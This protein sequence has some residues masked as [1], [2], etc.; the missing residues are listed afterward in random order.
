M[1][2]HYLE[3]KAEHPDT[4]LLYRMGDF[5]EAFFE[6]AEL[7]APILE[8][9]LTAR[10]KGKPSET[11]MCGVP[12]HALEVY[13][14][15]L[16]R[17]GVRVAICDQVEDPAEAKGLVKREVT[18]VVTPG[19]VSD[20]DL[21]ESK[22]ENCLAAL[23]WEGERGAGAFLDVSTGSFGVARWDDVAECLEELAVQRPRE[24]LVPEE[25]LPEEIEV[26][27]GGQEVCVTRSGPDS[28]IDP[29]DAAKR[30][31]VNWGWTTFAVSSSSLASRR[32]GRRLWRCATS[33]RP[34]RAI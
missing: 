17:A 27:L 7:A 11:P 32:S 28:S 34:R 31:S 8:V 9:A 25:G 15:K 10:Q 30:S 21:L 20:P 29:R 2:R 6:D 19:T 4:I 23:F 12:Y 3:V 26:W 14:G 1:L 13:L 18:R 22:E 16:L 33:G 24:V 5:Y